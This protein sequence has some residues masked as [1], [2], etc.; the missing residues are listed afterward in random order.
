LFI[1]TVT[2][3]YE[4]KRSHSF[5]LLGV[6]KSAFWSK[7]KIGDR[8][9]DIL[10]RIGCGIL[11]DPALKYACPVSGFRSSPMIR[12]NELW[13]THYLS[14]NIVGRLSSNKMAEI[15]ERANVVYQEAA[16]F[17]KEDAKILEEQCALHRNFIAE[18]NEM[19][20]IVDLEPEPFEEADSPVSPPLPLPKPRNYTCCKVAIL[21]TIAF[22]LAAIGISYF[23][24]ER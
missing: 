22:L 24:E 12:F 17:L 7:A 15:S 5:V 21:N 6:E 20:Q 2:G 8:I 4:P 11:L 10:D 23:V 16:K 14:P 19:A 3:E 1:Q 18:K 9:E 13:G